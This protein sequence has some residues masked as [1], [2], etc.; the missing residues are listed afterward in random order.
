MRRAYEPFAYTRDGDVYC[1][2][3]IGDDID[4]DETGAVFDWEYDN[5]DEC[6]IL[7]C[8]SC[9]EILDIG[10]R[11]G[12]SSILADSTRYCA[13]PAD[14]EAAAIARGQNA[15]E[16]L[17]IDDETAR[18]IIDG[19][20]DR[21]PEIMDYEPAWLSGEWSGETIAELGLEFAGL[22]DDERDERLDKYETECRDAFW[23]RLLARCDYYARA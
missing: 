13:L 4:D 12:C 6:Q 7:A 20:D 1:P 21:D 3:C 18:R 2:A 11:E 22:D 15:A 19:Y 9:R 14:I 17:D 16:W 5:F 8:G 10:H 23:D